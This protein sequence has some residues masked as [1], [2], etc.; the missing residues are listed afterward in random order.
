MVSR[1]QSIDTVNVAGF[2]PDRSQP[3][4]NAPPGP[5]MRAET[6]EMGPSNGRRGVGKHVRIGHAFAA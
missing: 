6:G 1:N 5:A 4:P 3:L 2:H